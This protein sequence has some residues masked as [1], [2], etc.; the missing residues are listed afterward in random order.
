[1]ELAGRVIGAVRAYPGLT[2]YRLAI[3]L[4][5]PETQ[6]QMAVTALASE[7]RLRSRRERASVRWYEPG[8]SDARRSSV[9]NAQ[10]GTR[11]WEALKLAS[12][13][14]NG[15]TPAQLAARTPISPSYAYR[16]LRRLQAEK[17]MVACPGERKWTMSEKGRQAIAESHGSTRLPW[18]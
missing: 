13:L 6:L 15:I 4:N 10:P 12:S 8:V 5:V 1:M 18:T 9:G 3:L 11:A 7:G 17:L 2:I 14:P 16:V